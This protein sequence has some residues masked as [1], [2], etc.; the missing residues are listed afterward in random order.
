MMLL[1]CIE[2]NFANIIMNGQIW[3]L[4]QITTDIILVSITNTIKM[5]SGHLQ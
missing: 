1:T 3:M 5:S 4:T 2:V